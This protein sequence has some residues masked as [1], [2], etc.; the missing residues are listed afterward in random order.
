MALTKL[1]FGGSQT[2]LS[3]VNMPSGSI[4]QKEIFHQSTST[5]LYTQSTTSAQVGNVQV[6]ITPKKAN[7]KILIEATTGMA[8][9]NQSYLSWELYQDSTPLI[10]VTQNYGSSYYYGWIYGRSTQGSFY[11]PL[12]AQHTVD[13]SSTNQR[14][15]KLYHRT[16]TGT[17]ISY[18][19]HAGSY[20][21]MIATEIAQ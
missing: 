20:I 1:N 3:S 10:Q 11:G 18:S 5:H 19:C 4:L 6:S 13:A 2:A 9:L 12:T 21:K 7:S 16:Y 8:L 14:T 15:Y 17:A